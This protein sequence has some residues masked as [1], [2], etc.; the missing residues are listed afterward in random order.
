MKLRVRV[1]TPAGEVD[2][3]TEFGEPTNTTSFANIIES[4]T[5]QVIA[6]YREIYTNGTSY[7]TVTDDKV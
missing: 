1:Q 4:V 2:F 3:F 5:N 7:F 6:A